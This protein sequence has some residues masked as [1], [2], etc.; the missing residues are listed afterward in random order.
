MS[1]TMTVPLRLMELENCTTLYLSDIL[2]MAVTQCI[3]CVVE[4]ILV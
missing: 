4:V 2:A 3:T 1:Y